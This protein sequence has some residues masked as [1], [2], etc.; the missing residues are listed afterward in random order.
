[1]PT[2]T[3]L[4]QTYLNTYLHR[5][6]GNAKPWTD[7]QCDQHLTDALSQSW[8]NGLGLFVSGTVATNESSDRYTIPASIELVSRVDIEQVAGGVTA[9]VD[10]VRNWRRFSSTQI[11]IRPRITTDST[12]S[13]RVY[14]WKRFATT[15]SDLVADLENVISMKAAS[16]AYGALSAELANSQRQQNL[17]SGRV[18]DYQTA[19]GM[20]AYYMRLYRESIDSHPN[21]M[22][23]APRAASR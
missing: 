13:L 12:L 22:S 6:D 20:S 9:I 19:V 7:A 10:T 15:A 3:S 18:V 23:V 5:T 14:G 17:D 11:L 2:I 21:R 4:R 8:A 1:M 16:L